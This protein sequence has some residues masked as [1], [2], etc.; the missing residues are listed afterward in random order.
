MDVVSYRHVSYQRPF[1]Q[2]RTRPSQPSSL[3]IASGS[4]VLQPF[5][6]R[7]ISEG[8]SGYI[9]Q[10]WGTVHRGMEVKLHTFYIST[11]DGDE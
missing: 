3:T 11:A 5:T 2:P 6:Q 1:H 9:Y 7:A 4:R 10:N 8:L